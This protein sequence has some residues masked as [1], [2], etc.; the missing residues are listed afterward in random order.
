VWP[1]HG[2]LRAI[3]YTDLVDAADEAAARDMREAVSYPVSYRMADPEH[4]AI[5][6]RGVAEWN[7]WREGTACPPDPATE[8][9]L[10][11]RSPL[12]A[13]SSRTCLQPQLLSAPRP[14]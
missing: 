13:K 10:A 11:E 3:T 14:R 9:A 2:S 7:A 6:K 8:L 5:L 12:G 4:L 1:T